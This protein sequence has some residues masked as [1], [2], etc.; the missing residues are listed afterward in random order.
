MVGF[1]RHVCATKIGKP[2]LTLCEWRVSYNTKYME[3]QD[4]RTQ[5]NEFLYGVIFDVDG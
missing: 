3:L 5:K 4:E 1:W 2:N